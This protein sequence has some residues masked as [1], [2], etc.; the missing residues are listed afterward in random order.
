MFTRRI[1]MTLAAAAASLALTAGPALARGGG[2]GGGGTP[3]APVLDAW[4]LC[5][6]YAQSGFIVAPDGSTSFANIVSGAACV[7]VR[8]YP[9]G[10]L[11]LADVRL[12]PGWTADVKSS[13]GGSSNRVNIEFNN[14]ATGGKGEILVAPGKTV[15]K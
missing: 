11:A 7:I 10:V 12:A 15:I 9:S 1:P 3:P 6:D 5:P 4:T 13:G 8:S 14:A 2:G